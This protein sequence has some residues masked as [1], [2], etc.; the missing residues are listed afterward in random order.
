MAADVAE[1]LA[2]AA[3]REGVD[4]GD[5]G[6]GTGGR[7]AIDAHLG[8]DRGDITV[9]AE[10]D[11]RLQ[12]LLAGAGFEW[13]RGWTADPAEAVRA[14]AV[15]RDGARLRGL[16]ERFPFLA[17]S[18]LAQAHEDGRALE[19][20]W[21]RLL[22]DP[23][24]APLARALRDNPVLGALG[25]TVSHGN[26]VRLEL[27]GRGLDYAEVHV[28]Q[29]RDGFQVEGSWGGTPRLVPTID[30]AVAEAVDLVRAH[31]HGG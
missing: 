5:I 11:G 17:T 27:G 29:L 2:E 21:Q 10:P 26:F 7:A 18:E 12:V 25:P 8:S 1:A 4:V 14:I 28:I 24:L 15:W 31:R 19:Y 13:A 16:T 6:R 20:R 22:D 30:E 23:A 9:T 3:G